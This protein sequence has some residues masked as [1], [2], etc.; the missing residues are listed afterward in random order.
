[1]R[2]ILLL[3]LLA[4][5]ACSAPGSGAPDRPTA[6]PALAALG[7]QHF[8]I[9]T[10]SAAAQDLFDQGLAWC[11]GFHHGEA[12]RCFDAA[13]AAD[14]EC[15]M[16]WWGRAYAAGPHI[17][18]M[19][20]SDDAARKA[21]ADAQ[22]AQALAAAT[23]PIERALIGAIAARYAWPAPA[24]RKQLDQAYAAAMKGVYRQ[25]GDHPDVAALY[26]EALMNLWP[27]DLWRAD[28][29]PQ[30]DTLEIVAVIERLLAAHPDH[31]Q[32]CHLY[33]HA[34][35]ASPQ[36]ERAV[37]AA[38]RLGARA[39][40]IGHLVHMPSHIFV[41]VGRYADSAEANRRGIAADLAIV[42]RTGRT[43]FYELYRAHNYHFL[44][45]S[46]MF[47]GRAEEANATA[48]QM[49]RELPLDVVQQMPAFLESFLA[50]PY[51]VLLRFGRWQEMLAE[52]EPPA[53]Q[54]STRAVWHYGRGVALAALGRV[55]EARAEQQAF[56]AAAAAVPEDW[57][58][59]NNP[60]RTV[61]A[62]GEAFLDGEVEFRAGNHDA[63]FA[64][65]R[66]AVERSDA[67]RYDEPWGW[68]TP[69]R[70]ALGAL[71][72]E[73][74]RAAEAEAV[75]R[76]DLHRHP[77]NGWA[78][79]GLAESLQ[80]QGKP[81]ATAVAERFAAVWRTSS[82]AIAASCYCRRTE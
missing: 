32:G 66:T 56:R 65:L 33:I 4:V 5:A 29:S 64:A 60:T 46:C 79:H 74:G 10:A 54:Q 48:R 26:A 75:Y 62:I 37:P 8:P 9:T 20:M 14:P 72:L 13:I 55:G 3:S 19:A 71:L 68:M 43:G 61:L 27:W 42:A 7:G 82:V 22:R 36:P 1:M 63:A 23:T 80:R 50:V 51:H 53:W 6:P 39:P 81:E 57:Y 25:H 44:T 58:V 45:W 77:D 15:A 28:G 47:A 30:P 49:L 31:I 73:A 78:L 24:E 40:A 52:P 12:L 21:H 69:P 11:Y 2:T 34:V 17:N 76:D 38:E 16:A 41:R 70:H 35:E 59:A 67:L 18:N